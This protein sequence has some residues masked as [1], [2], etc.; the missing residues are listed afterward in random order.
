MM[1][2]KSLSLIFLQLV[3]KIH[4]IVIYTSLMNLKITLVLFKTNFH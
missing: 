3:L 1:F 4:E 2:P